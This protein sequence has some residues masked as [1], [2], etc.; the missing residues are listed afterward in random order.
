V[1]RYAF[2]EGIRPHEL[3]RRKRRDLLLCDH[4]LLTTLHLCSAVSYG[5]FEPLYHKNTSP[6][7]VHH[8]SELATPPLPVSPLLLQVVAMPACRA[9]RRHGG[10]RSSL[11]VAAYC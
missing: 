3:M 11:P 7:P 8:S 9:R 4:P 5:H 6:A 10:H 1:A 2:I